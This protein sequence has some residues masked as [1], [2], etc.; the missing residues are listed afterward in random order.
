MFENFNK[1]D[2]EELLKRYEDKQNLEK[3]AIKEDVYKGLSL[4][5]TSFDLF[6]AKFQD[7]NPELTDEDFNFII[8]KRKGAN[9]IK[10][11]RVAENGFKL[12]AG[13]CIGVT[14][15][16]RGSKI[17]SPIIGYFKGRKINKIYHQ[18]SDPIIGAIPVGVNEYV[19]VARRK[20]TSFN[21]IFPIVF[22]YVLLCLLAAFF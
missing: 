20:F 4:K 3:E 13:S 15:L 1:E 11:S 17:G 9:Y 5:K 19:L 18:L 7:L 2:A 10:F 21:F 6:K 12:P 14:L 8:S 22:S 16:E